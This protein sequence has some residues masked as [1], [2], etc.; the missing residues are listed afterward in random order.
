MVAVEAVAQ[1]LSAVMVLALLAALA[2]R[3]PHQLF[4]A[5]LL[6]MQAAVEAEEMMLALPLRAVLAAG[7]TDHQTYLVPEWL[8]QLIQAVLVVVATML[9][10]EMAVPVS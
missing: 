5:H 10:V 4:R 8:A 6:P 3:A 7:V 2:A 9:P 1:A